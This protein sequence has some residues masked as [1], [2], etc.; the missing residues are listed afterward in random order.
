MLDRYELV[1]ANDAPWRDPVSWEFGLLSGVPKANNAA[2]AGGTFELLSTV[3]EAAPPKLLVMLRF[4]TAIHVKNWALFDEC[5]GSGPLAD[6]ASHA[7][8]HGA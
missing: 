2:L 6:F 4:D 1:T 7:L 5:L 3:V 8:K